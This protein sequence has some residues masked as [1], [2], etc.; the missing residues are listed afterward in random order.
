MIS[1]CNLNNKSFS[2]IFYAAS[3]AWPKIK[4][5]KK[6]KIEKKAVQFQATFHGL[7]VTN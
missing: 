4:K 5:K 7:K 2:I 6:K 3:F 1:F